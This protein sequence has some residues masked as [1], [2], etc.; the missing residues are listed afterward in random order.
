ML[1]AKNN[2]LLALRE[3]RTIARKAIAQRTVA[4]ELPDHRCGYI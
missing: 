4:M 1:K 2:P 3:L